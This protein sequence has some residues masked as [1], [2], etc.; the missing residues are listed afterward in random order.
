MEKQFAIPFLHF[1]IH[2][3]NRTI[4]FIYL[5][6]HTNIQTY[7]DTE[8]N[9][10]KQ[11]GIY[12]YIK[13]TITTI[14]VLHKYNNMRAQVERPAR[15]GKLSGCSRLF[16]LSVLVAALTS[17]VISQYV[18]ADP[19]QEAVNQTPDINLQTSKTEKATQELAS[20][21][22]APEKIET[23]KADAKLN[24][25]SPV[26][27]AVSPKTADKD[28]V[29]ADPKEDLASSSSSSSSKQ[30]R[31]ARSEPSA[32]SSSDSSS[33]TEANKSTSGSEKDKST[34]EKKSSESKPTTS[35][36]AKQSKPSS[37]SSSKT[38]SKPKHQANIG[39][40]G[41]GMYKH[42]PD[43]IAKIVEL[44]HNSVA[45]K[46]KASDNRRTSNTGFGGVQKASAIGDMFSPIKGVT[47][48]GLARSKYTH[49]YTYSGL[50]RMKQHR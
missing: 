22:V 24:E 17:V 29:L 26:E 12:I 36:A 2:C 49:S 34:N 14:G 39:S 21:I 44:Q 1:I 28:A 9:T 8:T 31:Q 30:Q 13:T 19:L 6:N 18:I 5:Y 46:M 25:P 48:S 40:G 20:P 50:N 11:I 42:K 7:I 3:T 23:P 37:S 41:G 33:S 27:A 15:T 35:T 47:D 32:T 43:E 16:A 4:E 10:D 38:V 45:H